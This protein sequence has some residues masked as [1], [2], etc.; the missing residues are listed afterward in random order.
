MIERWRA[1]G[2]LTVQLGLIL[3]VFW[4]A[5]LMSPLLGSVLGA[6]VVS[7]ASVFVSWRMVG[8]L[9][10]ALG[11]LVGG[12]VYAKEAADHVSAVQ[13]SIPKSAVPV[14]GEVIS[15]PR[16]KSQAF[17]Y[18][19]RI[20]NVSAGGIQAL[21]GEVLRIYDRHPQVRFAY[22]DQIKIN[23]EI[24]VPEK[25]SYRKYLASTGE[26]GVMYRP[27]VTAG[28][29][30]RCDV[31]CTTVRGIFGVRTALLNQIGKLFPGVEG[32]FVKG[33]LAGH[34][35]R[36]PERY[37]TAFQRTGITHLLA[38][39]GYHVTILMI[40]IRQVLGRVGMRVSWQLVI[41]FLILASFVIFIG[42]HG[43][44]VRASVFLALVLSAQS[45]GRYFSGLRAL[46][47]AAFLLV[48]ANP[49]FVAWNIAFQLS[50]MAALG[51]FSLV[52]ALSSLWRGHDWKQF[53]GSIMLESV[54][55]ELFV[56]PLIIATFGT[57]SLISPFANL[58]IVPFI[59]PLMAISFGLAIL[60]MVP[61]LSSIMGLM[62]YP[63]QALVDLGLQMV[64]FLAGL[65][66]S[67]IEV[68]QIGWTWVLGS[69]LILGAITWYI[70]QYALRS[71]LTRSV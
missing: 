44:V 50:F 68:P 4:G 39:S 10:L 11:A 38:I 61:G 65:P 69:Y 37:E 56:L 18:A 12:V 52:P 62:A 47:L 7:I 59:P 43:S 54:A 41:T 5:W 24:T 36:I 25:E 40:V 46:V 30:E 26:M 35:D 3:G 20:T 15:Y 31:V 21:E 2:G 58:I 32:E 23:G 48:L 27:N 57:V 33:I 51:I 14:T 6:I 66:I 70:R 63:V 71:Y 13:N 49:L 9:L 19:V 60:S 55:A 29:G 16:E 42:F 64:Q 17:T 34:D 22:G 28:K 53:V 45:L 8:I 67:A 1:N